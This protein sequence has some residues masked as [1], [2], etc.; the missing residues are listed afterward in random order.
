MKAAAGFD[1]EMWRA[2]SAVLA[3]AIPDYAPT[4]K[5]E[6]ATHRGYD[7]VFE[8]REGLERQPWD[9]LLELCQARGRVMLIAEGGFGKISIVG[10]MYKQ[11]LV[12]GWWPVMVDL[13]T[14]GAAV[15]ERWQESDERIA[16][17]ELLLSEV[18]K[19]KTSELS[20][21]SA[22]DGKPRIVFVDGINEVDSRVAQELLAA[23]DEFAARNPLASV[24]ATDRLVRRQIRSDRWVLATIA[25]LSDEEIAKH[26]GQGLHGNELLRTAFFL[27]MAANSTIDSTSG[28]SAIRGFLERHTGLDAAGIDRAANAAFEAY[29]SGAAAGKSSRAFD[30]GQFRGIASPATTE[31]LEASGLLGRRDQ[32]AYFTHHLF[33]DY[34]ASLWL[35]RHSELWQP[36]VFDDVTFRASSFDALAL[37]LEQLQDPVQADAF[38][39]SV[40]DWNFYAVSYA[41]WKAESQGVSRVSEDTKTV[42]LTLLSEKAWDPLLATRTKV[43]D[44][45]HLFR[46][47]SLLRLLSATSL[48]EL[49]QLVEDDDSIGRLSPEWR[50]IFTTRPGAQVRDDQVERIE[51]RQPVIGWTVSNVLRRVRLTDSQEARLRELAEHEDRVVRWRVT[52]VLGAHPS[53]TNV[54]CL[55]ARLSTDKYDWVKYGAVRSLVEC[56]SRSEEL[57]EQIIDGLL[58]ELPQVSQSPALLAEFEKSLVLANPP[59][60]WAAAVEPLL[61]ALWAKAVS[62]E[63]QERWLRLAREVQRVSA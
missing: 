61:D 8:H 30:L 4:F 24:L 19:P 1:Q 18:G 16:R 10:R 40:Y 29:V 9:S 26:I 17:V 52:H 11:A 32:T 35:S 14:W 12:S 20:L 47:E 60:N 48:A 39:D 58:E 28:A 62:Y 50:G 42:L 33:H 2:E 5:F 13:R 22:P 49:V 59:K 21:L 54:S 37:T 6:V 63:E 56:A 27:N 36:G 3:A 41:L 7:E 23:L 43:L 53:A 25:P 51:E 45:L 44:G 38:M 55:F 31:Q 57:R 15:A 34:L 46:H